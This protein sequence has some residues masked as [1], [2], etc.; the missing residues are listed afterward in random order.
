MNIARHV[1]EPLDAN[2]VAQPCTPTDAT[3]LLSARY[4]TATI[5]IVGLVTLVAY[6]SMGSA[7]VM[8]QAASELRGLSV[9]GFAFGGPLATSILG[10]VAAGRSSDLHGP[11]RPA[12]WGGACFVAGLLLCASAGSM[13]WLLAG[14]LLTG[15]GAGLLAVALYALVGRVY[16]VAL[17]SRVF[18]ACATAWILPAL[19]APGLSGLIAQTLGWRWALLSIAGLIVPVFL[20][21]LPLRVA[22]PA[23]S[24]TS[25]A[26]P[27]RRLAWALVAS[28]GAL[29]LHS[30]G[31]MRHGPSPVSGV[32][33]ATL[34]LVAGIAVVAASGA[35]LPPG[36]LAARRGLPA[37]I[38]LNGL[39]QA[40][41]FGAQAFI[42][43]LLHRERGLSLALAGA[44]LTAGAVSWSLAAAYRVRLQRRTG[45]VVL[46]RTGLLMLAMGIGL[47]MVAI[48]PG[49]P[50]AFATIG[51]VVAGA[52]MG[53]V[54]PT[55]SIMTLAIAPASQQGHTGASLRL[56]AALMTTSILAVG[57]ALFATLLEVST[58]LAFA[59]GIGLTLVLALAGAAL[60]HRVEQ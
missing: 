32:W 51:W 18:A 54:S 5:A 8:P 13:A 28:L 6:E 48:A 9:Y 21:L 25:R 23:T 1:T 26:A 57:G 49:T 38:A 44:A 3:G 24:Q 19:I 20:L 22:A 56:S 52:G 46:L 10:M 33:T 53:L 29:V 14:R 4:R 16:P 50:S 11:L 47:A 58:S 31:Q 43:L 34:L 27:G 40:A 41:F 2:A 60:A 35:L 36:T 7:A 55:L 17:H 12:W 45:P 30:V 42:P 39:A 37:M 15:L 59:A